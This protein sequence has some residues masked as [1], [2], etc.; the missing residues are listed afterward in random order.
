MSVSD[1]AEIRRMIQTATIGDGD[2][3]L[4][5]LEKVCDKLDDLER[6][7]EVLDY[8]KADRP[9]NPKERM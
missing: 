2:Q 6:K 8:G 5:I 1:T 7:Q 9:Y 3:V 4:N